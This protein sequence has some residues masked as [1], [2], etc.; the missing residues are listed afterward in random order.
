LTVRDGGAALADAEATGGASEAAVTQPTTRAM[1]PA[2]TDL[3]RMSRSSPSMPPGN[4]RTDRRGLAVPSDRA[5]RAPSD[6]ILKR[7]ALLA[8]EQG[9]DR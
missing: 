5:V 6:G 1:T 7:S 4:R 9:E 8:D 2:R 3:T